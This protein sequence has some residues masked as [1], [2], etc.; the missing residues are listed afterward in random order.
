MNNIKHTFV[1]CAYK[2][3]PYLEDC[4]RSL[5][6]QEIESELI[7]TTSTPSEYIEKLAN[8]YDI[9]FIVNKD[10]GNIG[11][12]WNFAYKLAKTDLV[13][14][15]HQDDI[16]DKEYTKYILRAKKL[17]KD[18]SLFTCA[19][20]TIDEE[21]KFTKGKIE[22]IKTILRLPLRIFAL[23]NISLVKKLSIIIGNPIICPSCCYD[24][25]L[26]GE[27][28]FNT[29]YKFAL[30]WEALL[31]LSKDKNRWI[32][33]E[34]PLINYRVHKLSATKTCMENDDRQKEEKII[35]ESLWGRYIS[36]ILLTFYRRAYIAYEK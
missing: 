12:D 15:A 14:I 13:T 9:E 19:S 5:K 29:K 36:K 24:K 10:G 18:M 17:Y 20:N 30:D 31:R 2:D 21:N 26:C 35:F 1:I 22:I 34:K 33:V 6:A 28:L 25:K 7:L 16:Y 27:D 23:N 4:I 11:K 8:K 32:C 3:S